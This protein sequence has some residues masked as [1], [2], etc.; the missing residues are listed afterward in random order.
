[1]SP[2][3][4]LKVALT[5]KNQLQLLWICRRHNLSL[6]KLVSGDLYY[7]YNPFPH[8]HMYQTAPRTHLYN[9]F[10]ISSSHPQNGRNQKKSP[11]T[12]IPLNGGIH[13]HPCAKTEWKSMSHTG[14]PTRQG[15]KQPEERKS[16]LSQLIHRIYVVDEKITPDSRPKS[17][18]S[19][20]SKCLKTCL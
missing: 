8:K 18:T 1:M 16:G 5:F 9:T 6:W 7:T 2:T 10:F 13:L 11:Q 20:Q 4:I 17:P 14:A 12:L 3:I 19:A 15:C